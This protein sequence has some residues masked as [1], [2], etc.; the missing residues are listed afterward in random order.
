MINLAASNPISCWNDYALSGYSVLNPEQP[1]FYNIYPN[2]SSLYQETSRLTFT[3][4]ATAGVVAS[5]IV[6]TVD[7]VI[8]TNLSFSGPST[9]LNG[10][11][12]GLTLNR[13]HTATLKMTDNSGLTASTTFNFDT[14]NPTNYTFDADDYN[15]DGGKFFDNPQHGAYAGLSGIDGIDYHN[16]EPGR[17]ERRLSPATRRGWKRRMA[18]TSRFCV[19][20]RFAGL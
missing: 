17:G 6:V 18:P 2:G 8:Q 20:S 19:Q 15:Y 16:V 5:N 11:F 1:V 3:A 13:P 7:G 9:S 4:L 14:F 12:P 10:A